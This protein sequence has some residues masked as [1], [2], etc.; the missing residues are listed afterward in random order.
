MPDGKDPDEYI[1]EN[2]KWVNKFT[3]PKE[4]IQSLFGVT[5]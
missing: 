3:E 2:E 5:N 4:I 1:K